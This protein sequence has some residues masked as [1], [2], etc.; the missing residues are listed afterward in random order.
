MLGKYS[1]R[2]TSH[3]EQAYWDGNIEFLFTAYDRQLLCRVLRMGTRGLGP[4]E[5]ERFN[6]LYALLERGPNY[7]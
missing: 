5:L 2:Y 7:N 3:R 4:R 1:Q 6:Q